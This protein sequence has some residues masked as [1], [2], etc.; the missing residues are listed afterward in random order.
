[1]HVNKMALKNYGLREL[2]VKAS[3]NSCEQ[4]VRIS[5]FTTTRISLSD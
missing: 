4:G 3:G 1:M 5:G 2:R